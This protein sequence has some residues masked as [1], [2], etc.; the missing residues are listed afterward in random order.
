VA[1]TKCLLVTTKS[2]L[3]EARAWIDANLERLIHKSIPPDI[4]QPSSHLPR[5]LDKPVY[6]AMSQTYADIFK[7]Q[8]LLASTPT[9]HATD[10]NRPP[11]KRQAK[12]LDY[13]S[14][15]STGLPTTTS[16]SN[17]STCTLLPPGN[18]TAAMVDYM[19]ELVSLK[20]EL[21][22]LHTLIMTAVVQLKTEIASLHVTRMASDMET[23]AENSLT[24]TNPHPTTN[25][26]SNLMAEL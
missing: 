15:Q 14:D 12:I 16:N 3:L 25:E 24:A 6:L 7:K 18:L 19:T 26:L 22:P 2:N 20:T 5:C 23:E 9:T 1:R 8:F 10:N 17:S 11:H 13:N 21:Q 4:D